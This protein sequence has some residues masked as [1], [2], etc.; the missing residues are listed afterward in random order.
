MT[1]EEFGKRV[2]AK[3]DEL[4]D[5]MTMAQLVNCDMLQVNEEAIKLVQQEVFELQ[6]A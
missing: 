2:Q 5:S 6:T 4:T 3:M 1:S